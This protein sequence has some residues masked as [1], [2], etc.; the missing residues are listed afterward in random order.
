MDIAA[1]AL[2]SI[3]ASPAMAHAKEEAKDFSQICKAINGALTINIGTFDPYWQECALEAAKHANENNI[4]GFRS[5]GAGASG[6]EIKM[7][8]NLLN[9]NQQY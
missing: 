2:L 5:V 7:L 1:N 3:G 6:L 9:L 4:L 8:S